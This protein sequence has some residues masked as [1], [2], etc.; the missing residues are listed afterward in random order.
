MPASG[1]YKGLAYN[2]L[3][4]VVIM[5]V[6]E[7]IYPLNSSRI[8]IDHQPQLVFAVTTL[9]RQLLKNN[10]VA[11]AKT[12]KLFNLPVIYTPVEKNVS[13][14][15][16]GRSYWPGIPVIKRSLMNLAEDAALIEA[17][18]RPRV[19][20]DFPGADGAGSGL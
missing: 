14:V 1:I 19:K 2:L 8:F 11:L 18:K 13:V 20:T 15:L 7:L 10:T 9:F 16:S 6:R 3:N 4:G 5:S 17:E 12:G